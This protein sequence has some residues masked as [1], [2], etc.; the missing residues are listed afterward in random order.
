MKNSLDTFFN[1]PLK[2]LTV[3]MPTVEVSESTPGFTGEK[4]RSQSGRI[5]LQNEEALQNC[6]TVL[7]CNTLPIYSIPKQKP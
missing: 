6:M 4:P 2:R 7:E 5:K 1:F 3:I